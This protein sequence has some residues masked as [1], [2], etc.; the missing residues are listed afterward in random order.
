V[1][2]A[3]YNAAERTQEESPM[4]EM[5]ARELPQVERPLSPHLQI[6]SPLINMVM[7]I[8]HRITGGALYFGTLLL[9]WWLLAA[10][11]GPEHFETAN[12]FFGTI[13]GKLVLFGYTWALIHHALG[14]IRHLIWDTGRGFDLKTVDILCWG[15]IIGS[16]ALT[17]LVWVIALSVRGGL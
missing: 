4:A 16:V 14:G 7:S 3:R 6:Y 9:A 8:V 11:S 1:A 2:K 13:I 10:A 5:K 17:L 15:T 12:W